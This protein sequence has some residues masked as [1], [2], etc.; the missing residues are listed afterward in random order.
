MRDETPCWFVC[1]PDIRI[2][3]TLARLRSRADRAIPHPSGRP[4]LLG[5][6]RDD[7][8]TVARAGNSVLAVFGK[9]SASPAELETR[10]RRVRGPADVETAAEAL[11]GSYHLL[12]SMDGSCYL[13]GS[14]SGSR[15]CFHATV[16][17]VT[18]GADRARTLA[19]LID[20]DVDDRQLA[21]HLAYPVLPYPLSGRAMWRGVHAVAPDDA[22]LLA[23]EGTHRTTRWWRPPPADAG[24]DQGA[25]ALRRALREAVALRVRPGEVVGADLSG[26]M[27]ST[28][29][30][31][32]AAQAGARLVTASL[33]WSAPG[34]EDHAYAEYAA[35]HLPGVERLV[36]PSLEL[37]EFL[38]DSAHRHP[39][40]DEPMGIVR[41]RAQQ[42]AIAELMVARGASLRLT[43]HGG[44]Y[45][46]VPPAQYVHGFLRRR[47]LA[48]LRHLTGLRARGRWSLGASIR[49]SASRSTYSRWLL[50][51]NG[52]LRDTD[53][54]STPGEWGERFRLP[55]WADE[56]A[57]RMLGKLLR[58]AAGEATPLSDDRGRHAW[59]HQIR[60]AGRGA[61]V[62]AQISEQ[63]GL[64]TDSPFCDDS[65]VNACLSVLPE[66]ARDPWSY[67]PLLAAAMRGIVPPRILHRSTK[68][69]CTEEWFRGLRAHRRELM[70]WAEDSRLAARG[71]V[72]A[73]ALRRAV[74]GPAMLTGGFT[75]LDNTLGAEEW[76]RD[77]AAHPVPTYLSRTDTP[78]IHGRPRR[79]AWK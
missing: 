36:F 5:N 49:L 73:P 78:T 4:W 18:V 13:R 20:A 44:D 32:L 47:P 79:S 61:R 67:K 28:S 58:S 64:D 62:L 31:F 68:D 9:S 71:L 30:C 69:H 25:A 11:S 60:E 2:G 45:L 48:A 37:P 21:A 7:Q 35:E 59:I 10:V 51:A 41:D 75:Q 74:A 24:F 55:P 53:I 3:D 12:A 54:A 1:V 34:N 52:R 77:L 14:A 43:G 42:R 8:V 6:W 70:D 57:A 66:H 46:V 50:A 23:R 29:V 17:G 16:D 27:D 63:T 40:A 39:P 26:G 76:L 15:R 56:D 38:A 33:H 22:L 19:W 72:D 65:I